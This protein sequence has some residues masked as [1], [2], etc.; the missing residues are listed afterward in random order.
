VHRA[1]LI[2][3]RPERAEQCLSL[4]VSPLRNNGDEVIGRIINFQDLTELRHMEQQIRQAE[5]LAVVGTL[6]AGVA[7]EIRNP[8]AAISGSIELLRAS[9][10]ADE[11]SRTLMSIVTR[12]V[13]RL[14]RLITDLLDYTNPQPRELVRFDLVELARETMQVFAQDPVARERELALDAAPQVIELVAD[15]GRIRQL[16]WNLLRNGAEAARGRVALRLHRREDEA[17]LEIADD[18]PGI[19]PEHIERVFDPFFTTKSQGT[20]LG[21]ATCHSILREHGGAI[22]AENRR[23]GGCCF[24]VHLPLGI[25]GAHAPPA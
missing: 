20:G 10:Q 14:D 21:L 2:I 19:P 1:E 5:R 4:S 9:P 25:D 24:V 12:E 3:R 6:A 18:G 11:D 8:L 23:E 7:H 17:I 16:L 15:P 13:D 22:R